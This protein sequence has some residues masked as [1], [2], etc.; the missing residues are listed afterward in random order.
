MRE[1]SSCMHC[2][3]ARLARDGDD[4]LCVRYSPSIVDTFAAWP[5]VAEADWCGEFEL[6]PEL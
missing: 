6:D 4:L 5:I 2:K 3:F 1:N